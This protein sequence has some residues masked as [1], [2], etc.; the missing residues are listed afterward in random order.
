MTV[1]PSW[2]VAGW[3]TAN[4][5]LMFLLI[6]LGGTAWAIL[7]YAVSA[8]PMYGFAGLVWWN[9]R[10]HGDTAG[11]FHLS[12]RVGVDVL[13][14]VGIV[15]VG[16]GLVYA[17]WIMIFGGFFLVAALL[18]WR[19]PREAN[20]IRPGKPEQSPPAVEP[21]MDS[22]PEFEGR[23]AATFPRPSGSAELG[24]AHVG[25]S[26]WDKAL[27]RGLVAVL[28]LA[29]VRQRDGNGHSSS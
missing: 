26:R 27:G 11:S 13:A 1:K 22:V 29:R 18:L 3:T 4:A 5:L 6:G 15:L 20:P 24:Q 16:L 10:K 17:D 21:G 9:T 28:T 7:I 19:R 2:V 23:L 25:D 8:V 14:G 12:D